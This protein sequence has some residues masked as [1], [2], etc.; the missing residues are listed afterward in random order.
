MH[1][2]YAIG[3]FLFVA[4]SETLR[5][6]IFGL[7]PSEISAITAATLVL[8]SILFLR[9]D[10]AYLLRAPRDR[11][12]GRRRLAWS[13]GRTLRGAIAATALCGT[14]VLVATA[15]GLL[16]LR[17]LSPATLLDLTALQVVVATL[18]QALFFREAA[19]KACR[20][21][22]PAIYLVSTLACFIHFLPG[23]PAQAM[24]AAAVGT[25]FLTLRLCGV[26]ILAVAVL[27]GAAAVA[28]V[29]V[30]APAAT[31]GAA[32]WQVGGAVSAAAALLSLLLYRIFSVR[33]E[34]DMF[35]YA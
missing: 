13:W 20:Q 32:P 8:M 27:H 18:P 34:K 33:S 31:G 3:F 10:L 19:I 15:A 14:A 26:N 6:G 17:R 21:S 7:T 11:L 16:D 4:L 29:H 25:F 24:A 23:G 1:I 12:Y 22:L 35:E 30:I 2:A 28:L 5:H 9:G